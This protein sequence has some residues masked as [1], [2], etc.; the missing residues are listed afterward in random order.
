[1]R[2]DTGEVRWIDNRGRTELDAQGRPVRMLAAQLD[3]TERKAI[4]AALAESEARL[5]LA[6][7][8]AG[9]GAFDWNLV[10]GKAELSPE[11]LRIMGFD[12]VE[13]VSRGK[14]LARVHPEDRPRLSQELRAAE[15]GVGRIVSETRILL[16]DGRTRW[17]QSNARTLVD[18]TGRPVRRAGVIQDVTD[19]RAAEEALRES[20]ARFRAIT[21]SIDHMVWSTRPD[22]FHDFYNRRWYEFTGA[23]EG[24]TDGD[25]WAGLFHP[26][27][28]ARTWAA[29]RNSLSTGDPYLIEYRLRHH[30]GEYR[31]VLGRAQAVRDAAGRIT[32]WFGTCTDIQAIV[33]AREVLARS[34]LE[35]ES[36]V[37]ERTAELDRVWRNS[38]DLL[39]VIS[40]DGVFRA[41]SP[42][43]TRVLG[44]SPE[45]VAGRRFAEF[46]HPDDLASSL[47]ALSEAARESLTGYENRY[48]TVDGETR[49]ISWNTN[50]EGD[51]IYAYGRDVTA[52]K[53]AQAELDRAQE[54]L[55]QAQKMEAV[56][57]LTGGI[58][59]DF[60]NLLT[61]VVGGLDM[62]RSR[63]TE[64]RT[65]RLAENALQA[66]ER[67]AKLTG[68]LLAFS[69]T[70]RLNVE[71]VDVNAVIAG[72]GDL[73]ER[74]IG[75]GV[76][77]LTRLDPEAGAAT[78]D[79][80]Q[81]ELA[82]LNLAINA[83]DAMGPAGGSIIIATR[84]EDGRAIGLP[85]DCVAVCVSDDGPGMPPEVAARAFDPFYTTKP[86]GQ[87]TGLGLSQ[88][89]GIAVQSG[90]RATIDTAE[91]RGTTIRIL[92]PATDN[93]PASGV[94][95]S[96][97]GQPPVQPKGSIL[98]VDDD[99]DVRR[100]V[101]DTLDGLGYRV[102]QAASGPEGLQ[103]FAAEHPD[104][105]VLDFAMP[106]MTGAEVAE[107]ARS[108][109]PAQP[110]LFVSGYADTA[111][112]E[113]AV[114]DAAVL[115]KPFRVAELAA[116]AAA[117]LAR[118]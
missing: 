49:W 74:A 83:R 4:E 50:R 62:I 51:L 75:S 46:L 27:D 15:G 28:Q 60:N 91:G 8:A 113:R 24:T 99:E 94:V 86:V 47:D 76:E 5:R 35:L 95:G 112:I 115:R 54:Q 57:Q 118:T 96:G 81:L 78:T 16:P 67:G 87:G 34:R 109:R 53:A 32:R 106:G 9:I 64:E 29:W 77:V 26:D 37:A 48:L 111:A 59:H 11:Y 105:L 52:E 100:F 84:R 88:V 82:V 73:L 55:R 19:R 42:A 108:S 61:A 107:R 101:A 25:G 117:A 43:W 7:E 36:L 56:G 116:A 98:V 65:R 92:L 69:R 104:L 17:V 10:T 97:P 41:V 93:I 80:N 66:A 1:M 6:Q 14:L 3:I 30:T 18:E 40:V 79:A 38:R 90:G 13:D 102:L 2:P 33:E 58:A 44:H 21:D 68:Q 20:E 23:P 22:G 45:Q 89:Y 114:S 12:S 71:A 70:Q 31:W 110:V 103:I 85:A 39:V 63:T 72:M